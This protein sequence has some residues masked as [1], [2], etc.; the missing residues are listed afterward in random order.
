MVRMDLLAFHGYLASRKSAYIAV[1]SVSI[2]SAVS[3]RAQ[4]DSPLMETRGDTASIYSPTLDYDTPGMPALR[5]KGAYSWVVVPAIAFQAQTDRK[6][7]AMIVR[8]QGLPSPP[9]GVVFVVDG[10]TRLVSG[11]NWILAK[12]GGWVSAVQG[13]ELTRAIG[14]AHDLSITVLG[15]PP[16]EAR[17]QNRDLAAFR[18]VA[19][20]YDNNT[21][22]TGAP[23]VPPPGSV[24]AQGETS[25]PSGKQ[26]RMEYLNTRADEAAGL[27]RS[28]LMAG[29]KDPD[30]IQL[31][32][33]YGFRDLGHDQIFLTFEFMGRNTYGA[34]LRHQMGCIASCPKDKPC[35]FLNM[36]DVPY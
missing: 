3:G 7:L 18:A 29:A 36:A 22:Q 1:L 11:K 15:S 28:H 30:S 17:F 32:D 19:S 12:S 9:D 10:K 2:L 23:N 21:F 13:E 4:M 26:G 24:P 35:R 16:L 25:K 27:C 31:T 34:V 5:A 33:K 14:T 6:E 8:V 20:K